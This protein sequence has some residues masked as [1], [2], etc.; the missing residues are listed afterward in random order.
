MEVGKK[1]EH[2]LTK[3]WMLVLE[4]DD[5]RKIAMCRTKEYHVVAFNYFELREVR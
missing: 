2:V 4:V 3:D 1:V 5:E